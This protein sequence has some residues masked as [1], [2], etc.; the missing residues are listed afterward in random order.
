M[1]QSKRTS[2]IEALVNIVLGVG[3][4]LG[5]QYVVF[6]LVGIHDVSHSV[7]IQITAWFTAISF[8]RSYLIRRF[9]ATYIHQLAVK[10][11]RRKQ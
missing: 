4:A 9:F 10:A 8:A 7:H 3:V 2:A 1:Q 11:S 5:S 6:P